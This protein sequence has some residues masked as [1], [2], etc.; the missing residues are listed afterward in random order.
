MAEQDENAQAGGSG[1]DVKLI[2]IIVLSFVI[3]IGGS[4]WLTLALVGGGSQKQVVAVAKK[5]GQAE[6]RAV[7]ETDDAGDVDEEAEA[8]E[9]D[10]EAEEAEEA[11]DDKGDP[12][13]VSLSPE[14]VVNFQDKA[15][16]TK[17][18]KAELSV[19]T[20]DPEMVEAINKHMPAIR[21]NLVL[22][23][24]RQ[25]YE[26]LAPYEGK[27]RLRAEALAEVQR[28]LEK[29]TGRPGVKELFFSSFVIQ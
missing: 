14:F 26:D 29:Q 11:G 23:F 19:V 3:A 13:Y 2:I 25:I 1:R 18:L 28:V 21:N 4:V 5:A 12:I 9:A 6:E 22:L 24:G 16:N 8:D 27:E 15:K 20:V 17:Y 10:E 7:D